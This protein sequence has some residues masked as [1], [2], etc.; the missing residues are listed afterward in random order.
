MGVSLP[1]NEGEIKMKK[2]TEVK[3]SFT[4]KE[5]DTLFESN[6]LIHDDTLYDI[7]Q[8][9]QSETHVNPCTD[10]DFDTVLLHQALKELHK[11]SPRLFDE[12]I[13]SCKIEISKT[14][15]SSVTLTGLYVPDK[16]LDI[17]P[18]HKEQTLSLLTRFEEQGILD[19]C[20]FELCTF[21]AYL[22]K[23]CNHPNFEHGM[24]HI[25]RRLYCIND[26]YRCDFPESPRVE[27]LV[28]LNRCADSLFIA[29]KL[30]R[31]LLQCDNI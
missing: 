26:A 23:F 4:S 25:N 30:H 8:L 22:P 20:I 29:N 10:D 9:Y 19:R 24:Q 14:V 18:K 3:V 2:E 1:N 16:D 7:V 12:M 27:Q 17:Y 31:T 28:E 5:Y 13:K 11:Y 15:Q 21:L 6:L